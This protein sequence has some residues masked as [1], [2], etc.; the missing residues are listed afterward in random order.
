M[1]F[2]KKN[3]ASLFIFAICMLQA[4]TTN[5]SSSSATGRTDTLAIF[6][7]TGF[8]VGAYFTGWPGAYAGF[9]DTLY[10]PCQFEVDCY[11]MPYEIPEITANG[12]QLKKDY[13]ING[14]TMWTPYYF[15]AKRTGDSVIYSIR[16]Q[17][18]VL[19]DTFYILR[20]V[21]SLFVNN[22][23]VYC[24]GQVNSNR[25]MQVSLR[26][27][28]LKNARSFGLV[29]EKYYSQNIFTSLPRLDTIVGQTD[30]VFTPESIL[31]SILIRLYPLQI[32]PLIL[33]V[34][35]DA[36]SRTMYVRYKDAFNDYDVMIRFN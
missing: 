13:N 31:D 28:A 10:T 1:R 33:G 27:P 15:N 9:C 5:P 32:Q 3:A 36:E 25:T 23:Y 12:I 14:Y 7:K 20:P 24:G 11:G 19:T 16:T 22:R 26:W 30:F 2:L 17:E 35:P 29:A 6:G 34:G 4:C 8:L 18:D 21:D